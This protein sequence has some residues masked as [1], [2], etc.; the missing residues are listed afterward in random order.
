MPN[1]L[2]AIR[3]RE[4]MRAMKPWFGVALICL[5]ALACNR[6][7]V[8]TGDAARLGL[9]QSEVDNL[10]AAAMEAA[11]NEGYDT[12]RANFSLVREGEHYKGLFTQKAKDAVGGE[13][14]VVMDK[15][16]RVFRVYHGL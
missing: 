16:G 14:H 10:R 13:L 2:D 1:R 5:G 11:R 7:D 9:A 6:T 3:N 15:S 4:V 12:G 8:S